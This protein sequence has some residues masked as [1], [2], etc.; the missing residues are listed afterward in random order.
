GFI[1][2]AP[3]EP[4]A[5]L[6]YARTHGHEWILP[7]ADALVAAGP[8]IVEEAHGSALRVGTWTVDDEDRLAEL[9]AWGVDAVASNDPALAVRVRD[10]VRAAR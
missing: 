9:F 10:R 5:A 2:V 4:A 1:T 6:V 7:Q 8:G 3:I